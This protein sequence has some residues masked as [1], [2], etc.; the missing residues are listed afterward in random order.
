MAFRAWSARHVGAVWIIGL[1]AQLVLVCG[2]AL[3]NRA[4]DRC[5]RLGAVDCSLRSL[6]F[7]SFQQS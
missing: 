1:V 6:L 7:R 5:C 2:V 4:T 3:Y